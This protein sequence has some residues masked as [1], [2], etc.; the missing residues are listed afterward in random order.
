MK[1]RIINHLFGIIG[2]GNQL[3]AVLPS[4]RRNK[5]ET[6]RLPCDTVGAE[7]IPPEN[8]VRPCTP[9]TEGNRPVAITVPQHDSGGSADC[10]LQPWCDR[11]PRV[12]DP[13]AD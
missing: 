3:W 10:S 9:S 7:K 6:A 1:V 13:R 4:S 12:S 2:T 8:Q 5:F 11:R